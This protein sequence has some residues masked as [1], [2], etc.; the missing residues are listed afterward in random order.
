MVPLEFHEAFSIS[1]LATF[2]REF[3][4]IC[5][6]TVRIVLVDELTSY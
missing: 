1:K 5:E 4:D 6:E 3:K 2:A